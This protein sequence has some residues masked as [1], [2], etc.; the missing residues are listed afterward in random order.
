[1]TFKTFEEKA[2]YGMEQL[3]N[4]NAELAEKLEIEKANVDFYKD[5][6]AKYKELIYLF[7]AKYRNCA[8]MDGKAIDFEAIYPIDGAVYKRA[9]TLLEELGVVLRDA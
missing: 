7:G 1:M 8:T 6:E 4:K 5:R 3:E 9:Q 2:L